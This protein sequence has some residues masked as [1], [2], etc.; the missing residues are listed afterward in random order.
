[1]TT[2][3]PA[4]LSVVIPVFN[5]EPNVAALAQKLHAAISGIGR[6]YEIILVDDGSRDGTWDRLKA[7]CAA[8]PHFRLIRFRRNFGQTAAMSA[9]IDAAKNDVIRDADADLQNDSADIPRPAGGD[10][11]NDY[12][13]VS[14]WRKDRK[15]P[16]STA[17]CPR[18]IA[19]GLISNITGVKLHDYGCT[20]KGLPPR[21]DLARGAALTAK[22][23]GSSRRCARG[24]GGDIP[25]WS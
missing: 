14:G 10:G 5:E 25:R 21:R 20:L 23:T 19:N 11:E 17:A 16:L 8:Y 6:A 7:A 13:V 2:S 24:F 12:A 18:W 9:G 4:S 15:D 3:S 22:C 1:M